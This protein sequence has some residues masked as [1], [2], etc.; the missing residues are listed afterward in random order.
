MTL[1]NRTLAV[2]ADELRMAFKRETS[3]ILAIGNLLIEAKMQVSHGEWLS[4]LKEFP[5]P[6]RSAQKYIKAAQFAAKYELSADLNLSPNALYLLSEDRYWRDGCGRDEA[7]REVINAAKTE[8]IGEDKAKEIIDKILTEK[9]KQKA[10]EKSIA[11]AMASDIENAERDANERGD[12]WSDKKDQWTENWKLEKWGPA[13]EA[14]FEID[15]EDARAQDRERVGHAG[16]AG[17]ESQA[18]SSPSGHPGLQSS[19]PGRNVVTHIQDR[20]RPRA[21]LTSARDAGRTEC[22]IQIGRLV[23]ELMQWLSH[24]C[25]D[26]QGR[27]MLG[28]TRD[29]YTPLEGFMTSNGKLRFNSSNLE[30]YERLLTTRG[31]QGDG[32]ARDAADDLAPHHSKQVAA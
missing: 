28:R 11:D 25:L 16:V 8:R 24:P 6:E 23:G 27:A 2:I 14:K 30:E 4:W 1:R 26:D 3:E 5:I 22:T 7:T 32:A 13:Q 21:A 29:G 20:A 9:A 18:C 10:H 12:C 19:Q 17:H 15:W 31:S